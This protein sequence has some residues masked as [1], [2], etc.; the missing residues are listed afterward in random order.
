[1]SF[2]MRVF[3]RDALSPSLSELLVWLRQYETP[4]TISGGSS[5]DD[6]LSSFWEEVVLS[7]DAE[8]APLTLR[9]YRGSGPG[10]ARLAEEVADFVADVGEL[11]DSPARARVLADLRAAEAL[12]VIE[13]PPEGVSFAGQ[14]TAEGVA[15]LFVDKTGGLAQRD[16]VGFLDE[17]DEVILEMA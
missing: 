5:R 8:E 16:G 13:Y 7:Y 14:Q 1:M 6:L 15:T 3:C 4:A 2:C 9:C 10:G 11:P 12:L 17:D